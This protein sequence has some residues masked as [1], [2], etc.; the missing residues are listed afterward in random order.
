MQED[1]LPTSRDHRLEISEDGSSM[2]N[3]SSNYFNLN[4]FRV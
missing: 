2:L 4:I 1:E 3:V